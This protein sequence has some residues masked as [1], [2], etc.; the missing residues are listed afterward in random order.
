M[1][2]VVLLLLVLL[3]SGY[4]A[5][6]QGWLRAYGLGP[7]EQREPHRLQQQIHPEAM[8][9]L[10]DAQAQ[11]SQVV[12]SAA[13]TAASEAAASAAPAPSPAPAASGVA[14]VAEASALCLQSALIDPPHAQTVRA[15]LS[16]AM[17]APSWQLLEVVAPE[18]WIIY[19]G[20]YANAA[21]LA[22]K[23][24]QLDNLRLT[25]EPLTNSALA[26]GLSLGV[27]ATQQQATA[28]LEALSKR[29]VRT[30]R[31]LQEQP[32]RTAWRLRLP[33]VDDGMQALLPKVR[34]A[35][36]GLPLLN[37]PPATRPAPQAP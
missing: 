11:A 1:L 34:Q 26:P 7:V 32:Q 19:M 8:V 12:A 16:G 14:S 18:R 17:P 20:K 5:W 31:V 29:G 3:N 13:A 15:L 37:C 24:A 27:F 30:A 25:F 22:K 10:S 21:E 35:L 28:A 36:G 6:G 2:R 23:R 9:V 33:A 4:F